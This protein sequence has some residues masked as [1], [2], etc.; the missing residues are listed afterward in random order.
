MPLPPTS[1]LASLS[2]RRPL[3]LQ[4][5]PVLLG[6]SAVRGTRMTGLKAEL[7]CG[8]YMAALRADAATRSFA[9]RQLRAWKLTFGDNGQGSA[10]LGERPFNQMS[11]HLRL[12]RSSFSATGTS[13]R[14]LH[15]QFLRLD[16]VGP[17]T[18]RLAPPH[19]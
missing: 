3:S 16:F 10:L 13:G 17:V 9:W 14:R 6:A 11:S 2:W 1:P 7:T 5:R 15:G 18:C 8:G 12:A 4:T 19:A